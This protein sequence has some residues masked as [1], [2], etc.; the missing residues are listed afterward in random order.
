MSDQ[1]LE[2]REEDLIVAEEE[3]LDEFKASMGDP[4]EVPGP[5]NAKAKAPGSSKNVVDDPQDAPTAVK[6]EKGQEPKTKMGMIQAMVDRM[7]GMKKADLQA[8]YGKMHA[9]MQKEDLDIEEAGA[10]DVVEVVRAGHKITVEDI[11]IK[12]D[13]EAV[14]SNDENLTEDFKTAATTIFEAAVVSK[15]NEQLERYVVDLDSELNEEKTRL[16]EEMSAKLDQYLDYVVE[17]WMEENKLAVEA[18]IKSE[19]TEDFING[20]KDLFAEHYIEIPDDRVDVVEELAVRAEELEAR[21]DEEISKNAELKV[22][23]SEHSKS[24]LFAAAAESL[25]ETQ[26]EKFKVL[27]EGIEFVNEDVYVTK[28]DTLKKSYFTES[29]T[30]EYTATVSDFDD[31]EPLEEEVKPSNLE[32]EMSAYVNAISRT[33]KK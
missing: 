32:P 25:T 33:L 6:P 30:T 13:I 7:N 24:E 22:Q 23:V 1:D 14:F 27:A 21:L 2:M 12:E 28:L 11:D 20:L 19:L 16:E 10:D 5:T 8:A 4:S 9:A 15:V 26:K 29:S 31:D 3:Q 17:Q 18:G